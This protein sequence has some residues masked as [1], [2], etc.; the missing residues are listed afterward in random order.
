VA[1]ND[2]LGKYAPKLSQIPGLTVV[3]DFLQHLVWLPENY[4]DFSLLKNFFILRQFLRDH[5]QQ[6]LRG[7]ILSLLHDKLRSMLG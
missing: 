1:L 3:H 6:L 2:I 5:L 4:R 7:P